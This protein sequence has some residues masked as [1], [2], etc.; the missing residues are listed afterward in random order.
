MGTTDWLKYVRVMFEGAIYSYCKT[1]NFVLFER[2]FFFQKGFSLAKELFNVIIH[3]QKS[4][5]MKRSFDLMFH[6]YTLHSDFSN[7]S[8][9]MAF[10]PNHLWPPQLD[11]PAQNGS[12]V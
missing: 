6:P 1:Q 5:H 11:E 12:F 4:L 10:S 3:F 7:H 8:L 2:V 9:Y